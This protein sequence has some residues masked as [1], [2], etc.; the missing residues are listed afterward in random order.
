MEKKH[1][2][3]TQQ[4]G[5]NGFGKPSPTPLQYGENLFTKSVTSPSGG[6]TVSKLMEFRNAIFEIETLQLKVGEQIAV[7]LF[8]QTRL[9]EK[10]RN[11]NRAMEEYLNGQG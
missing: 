10:L 7:I 11:A 1:P 9:A 8:E 3:R 4:N 6:I 5:A 2:P